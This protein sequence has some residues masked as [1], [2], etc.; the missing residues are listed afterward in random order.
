MHYLAPDTSVVIDG[1]ISA[2]VK[3]GDPAGERIIIPEDVVAK[4][5]A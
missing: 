5:E 4:L 3:S 1:R 2:R